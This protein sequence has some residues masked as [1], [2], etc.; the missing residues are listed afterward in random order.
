M[1]STN[2]SCVE[3]KVTEVALNP[4]GAGAPDGAANVGAVLL[5]ALVMARDGDEALDGVGALDGDGTLP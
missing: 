1:P 4:A 2:A 3:T 5:G